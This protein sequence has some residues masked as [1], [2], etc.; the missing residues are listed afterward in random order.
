MIDNFGI[1]LEA[2]KVAKTW[3]ELDE[4]FTIKIHKQKYNCAAAYYNDA[5]CL[6]KVKDVK[7]PT[8]VVHSED[9]PIIPIDCL[10]IEECKANKN[11]ITAVTRRGGHVCYFHGQNCDERWYPKVTVEYLDSVI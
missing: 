5:S 10:P 6:F 9:D 4:Q 8:L 7:V 3:R 11:I 1:D 2:I